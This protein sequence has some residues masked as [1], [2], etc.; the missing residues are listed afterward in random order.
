MKYL[1]TLLNPKK[2]DD[3]QKEINTCVLKLYLEV[4]EKNLSKSRKELVELLI[5]STHHIFIEEVEPKLNE[6]KMFNSLALLAKNIGD[7]KK[8]LT[9][10]FK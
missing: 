3:L 6:H 5:K 8:A 7:Y 9:I 1:E 10:W 2:S 4:D